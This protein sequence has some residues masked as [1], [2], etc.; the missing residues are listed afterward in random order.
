[1]AKQIAMGIYEKANVLQ[2]FGTVFNDWTRTNTKW[3][4]FWVSW[5]PTRGGGS[6]SDYVFALDEQIRIARRLQLGVIL[7]FVNFPSWVNGVTDQEPDYRR[8]PPVDL[9]PTSWYATYLAWVMLR[10]SQLN[11]NNGGAY[12]NILE[13]CNE[14]NLYRERVGIPL[15]FHAGRMMMTARQIQ[16]NGLV[17]PLLAAPAVADIASNPPNPGEQ[18]RGCRPFVAALCNYLRSQGFAPDGFWMWTQHNY[19]DIRNGTTTLAQAVRD[20]LKANGFWTAFPT[21]DASNPVIY[22]TEG[23]SRM[24]DAGTVAV[25]DATM[26]Q[27]YANCH[28]DDPN[29]GQGLGMFTN[30]LDISSTDPDH[31]TGLRDPVSLEPRPLYWT[32]AGFP[33]T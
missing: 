10:W 16:L 20:R 4:R 15:H 13:I 29:R 14:P 6:V 11:P 21:L 19:T 18:E 28:N 9:S 12:C 3:V 1:M 30:Y 2:N 5:D 22:L 23:G 26:R 24:V 27:A 17:S 7:T 32:W 8:L 25:Q 33:V 31:D